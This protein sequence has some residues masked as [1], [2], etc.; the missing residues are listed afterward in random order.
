LWHS[1]YCC[2]RVV[3]EVFLRN[4]LHSFCYNYSLLFGFHGYELCS[5][6]GNG[7]CGRFPQ[8]III[9]IIL[10]PW[11]VLWWLCQG[12]MWIGSYVIK[13]LYLE[14]CELEPYSLWN[15]NHSGRAIQ[16]SACMRTNPLNH[17]D[18]K[19]IVLCAL[20]SNNN[21]EL[22]VHVKYCHFNI[23]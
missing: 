19:V 1:Q 15:A 10:E 12:W 11:S 23:V 21:C 4:G 2:L 22:K 14:K 17:T 16:V 7:T 8:F 5:L 18:C 20:E 13:K 9:I 6:P 3:T